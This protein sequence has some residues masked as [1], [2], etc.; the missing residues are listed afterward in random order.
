MF[1]GIFSSTSFAVPSSFFPSHCSLWTYVR[2]GTAF[3]L[4]SQFTCS[5]S[6]SSRSSHISVV[7]SQ[8][9]SVSTSRIPS[10]S[11]PTVLHT[12]PPRF[13]LCF[14]DCIPW[15]LSVLRFV[16]CLFVFRVFVVLWW[17]LVVPH[18]VLGVF[19]FYHSSHA[20]TSSSSSSSSSSPSHS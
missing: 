18:H 8:V 15:A 2:L 20:R 5:F 14:G 19:R 12:I 1:F 3:S 9:Q 17:L 13:H 6:S 10:W 7:G 4:I 11:D 16:F